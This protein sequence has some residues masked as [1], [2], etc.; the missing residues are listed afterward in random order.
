MRPFIM[1]GHERAIKKVMYNKDGDLLFSSGDDNYVTMWD[2]KDGSRIGTFGFPKLS[3]DEDKGLSDVELRAHKESKSHNGVIW[4]M[5]ISWDSS[6]LITGSKDME[7]FVWDVLTGRFLKSFRQ[8]GTVDGLNFS[9]SGDRFACAVHQFKSKG[10]MS[11]CMIRFYESPLS[12]NPEDW[13]PEPLFEIPYNRSASSTSA[14]QQST[15]AS[16]P[17]ATGVY[18]FDMDTKVVVPFDNGDI[19][20]YD[21]ETGDEIHVIKEHESSVQRICFNKDRSMMITASK[22]NTAKLF[23][24]ETFEVFKTYTQDRPILD[25]CIHPTKDHV[26]LS[27]GK[28]AQA[29]ATTGGHLKNTK[30]FHLVYEDEFGRLGGHNGA[31]NAVAVSPDGLSFTTG[32]QEGNLRLHYFDQDYIDMEDPVPLDFDLDTEE[33]A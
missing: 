23:D 14:T 32:G 30:F 10:V 4:H 6:T 8:P 5:D 25:I 24:V 13:N 1:M 26:I 17:H 19:R 18:W 7:V 31:V 20:V 12:L 16:V 28:D 11:P 15:A 33:G 2:S 22:D 21:V 9:Q 29:E 27:G 3:I